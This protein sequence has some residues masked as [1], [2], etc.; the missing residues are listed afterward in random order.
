MMQTTTAA[1]TVP[2]RITT[3][4]TAAVLDGAWDVFRCRNCRRVLF[5]F[6]D[7]QQQRIAMIRQAMQKFDGLVAS[8]AISLEERDVFV[9]AF[10]FQ[11]KIEIKCT[12]TACKT[13]NYLIE[14]VR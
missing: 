6:D 2:S 10:K 9:N 11:R 13:M 1:Q 5:K 7:G 4:A 3:T 14:S 12:L 8:G